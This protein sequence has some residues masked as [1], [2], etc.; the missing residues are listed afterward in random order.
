MADG[1]L[2]I[3][4]ISSGIFRSKS[5]SNPASLLIYKA[6]GFGVIM[7]LSFIFNCV[8]LVVLRRMREI[9]AVTRVFLTSMT[10]ADIAA[11]VLYTPLLISTIHDK[12]V[13]G[14]TFCSVYAHLWFS[15]GTITYCGLP[16]VNLERFIAVV[17]PYR[18][19]SL[20]TV[21]RSRGVVIC[22]WSSS[23]AVSL[24][25]CFHGQSVRYIPYYHVC[26]PSTTNTL[27]I[28]F[29]MSSLLP[30]IV[31]L[32]LC[33]ILC[34]VTRHH[35]R[36][37]DAQERIVNINSVNKLERKTFM[38]FFIMTACFT[39]CLVPQ[40]IIMIL[41]NLRTTEA[42]N[43]WSACLAQQFALCN[44][45]FNVLVYYW[46]TKAFRKSVTDALADLKEFITKLYK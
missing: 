26:F 45:M 29:S 21:S 15:I 6:T 18:Y 27:S 5:A 13:F 37:I 46:R 11:I 12:W 40:S 8:S 16:F 10:V 42:P 30:I 38:T 34:R 1:N 25:L 22:T 19:P 43:A 35:A 44:T 17:L 28:I 9:N 39:F 24:I 32:C 4:T 36:Q 33:G 31:D 3:S 14:E 7:L 41:Y 23:F 2:N 20:V